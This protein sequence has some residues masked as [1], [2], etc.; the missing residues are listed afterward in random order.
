MDTVAFLRNVKKFVLD[1]KPPATIEPEVLTYIHML[2][3]NP[4]T[5]GNGFAFNLFCGD[6]GTRTC[7]L[8]RVKHAL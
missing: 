4:S 8:M 2:K 3:A 7:D 1:L 6:Y 5:K